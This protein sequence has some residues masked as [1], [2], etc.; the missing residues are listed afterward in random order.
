M[1]GCLTQAQAS[2][3]QQTAHIGPAAL[4]GTIFAV[5]ATVPATFDAAGFTASGMD[6]VTITNVKSFPKIGSKRSETTWTPI[7]GDST[8]LFGTPN[9][10]GGDVTVA[11]VP[12]DAG[13]V[14]LKAAEATPSNLAWKITFPDAR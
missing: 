11:D 9:Y 13:V 4:A 6:Y 10:G 1:L 5:S 12:G 3:L 2:Q 7:N 14:I 8:H